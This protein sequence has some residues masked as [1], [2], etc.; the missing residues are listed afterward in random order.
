VFDIGTGELL[1]LAILALLVLGPEKL[2]RYAADAAR[3]LRQVR[4]LAND[5]RS[6]VTKELGPELDGLNLAEMNPRALLRKHLLDGMEG[7]L[8]PS[9]MNPRALLRK[10]L[11]DGM[12]DDLNNDDPALRRASPRERPE[13]AA[14]S[15]YDPDTT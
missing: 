13:A 1:A 15:P 12:E 3:F 8:S 10:H 4:N 14:E 6:E 2:P 7:D 9:E 11:L 5:A